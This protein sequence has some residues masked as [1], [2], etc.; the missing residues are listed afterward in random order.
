MDTTNT[1]PA[2]LALKGV[3]ATGDSPVH[4]CSW[5]L[6]VQRADG[7]WKSGAW[8]RVAGKIAYRSR[9]L[10]VCGPEQIGYWRGH[11]KAELVVY[12]CEYRGQ[13]D[14][15][16]HGFAAREVRLLRVW[17]GVETLD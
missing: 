2:R 3:T 1:A 12:V 11:C 10:H 16:M 17:D 7:S 15:G 6:P 4:G 13:T 5:V 14:A 8:N 9:G